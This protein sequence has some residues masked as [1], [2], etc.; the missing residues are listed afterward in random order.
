MGHDAVSAVIPGMADATEVAQA[1]TL[2]T[3]AIPPALWTD[4]IDAGLIRADTPIPSE[5]A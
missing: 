5:T 4:L 2:A 3:L 1:V